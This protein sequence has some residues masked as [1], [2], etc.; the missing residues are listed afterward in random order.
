M[1]RDTSIIAVIITLT[2]TNILPAEKLIPNSNDIERII[3]RAE[4]SI[5]GKSSHAVATMTVITPDYK[6]KL[7]ME[8]WWVGNEAR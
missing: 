6:R 8:S 1:K 2:L 5:K 3:D 7:K 4:N